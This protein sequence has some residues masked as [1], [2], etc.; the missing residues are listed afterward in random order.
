MLFSR[1]WPLAV[2]FCFFVLLAHDLLPAAVW[3]VLADDGAGFFIFFWGAMIAQSVT[4]GF[5]AVASTWQQ[6]PKWGGTR[7]FAAF[8]A[9]MAALSVLITL[10]FTIA[11]NHGS[12]VAWPGQSDFVVQYIVGGIFYFVWSLVGI[13]WREMADRAASGALA[14]K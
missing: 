14:S 11:M 2:A 13:V 12:F 7:G 3:Q 1:V 6:L 8:T 5:F 10:K 4:A 9:L